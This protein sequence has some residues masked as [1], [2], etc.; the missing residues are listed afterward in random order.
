MRANEG[1]MALAGAPTSDGAVAAPEEPVV[2]PNAPP[3]PED[4]TTSDMLSG[5]IAMAV[6]R[7][8]AEAASTGAAVEQQNLE[9][10][11]LLE[12][13]SISGGGG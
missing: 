6:G 8:D 1:G 4:Q 10:D 5:D 7:E 9:R 13:M 11:A 2:D 12:L 3:P